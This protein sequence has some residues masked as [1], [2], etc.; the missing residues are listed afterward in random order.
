MSLAE[1]QN[2]INGVFDLCP[3]LDIIN[4]TCRLELKFEL[5]QGSNGR[6]PIDPFTI[7]T[8]VHQSSLAH[9]TSILNRNKRRGRKFGTRDAKVKGIGE[10]TK[11]YKQTKICAL[12]NHQSFTSYK[13][14]QANLII[15]LSLIHI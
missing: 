1:P 10:L 4:K 7:K 8:N 14:Q 5:K 9:F 12:L 3:E 6:L 13:Y 15:H 2:S 11:N